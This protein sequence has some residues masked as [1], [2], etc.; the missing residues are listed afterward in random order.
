[1]ING[2]IRKKQQWLLAYFLLGIAVLALVVILILKHHHH[3][4]PVHKKPN[5]AGLTTNTDFVAANQ[6][7]AIVSQQEQMKR[8]QKKLATLNDQLKGIQSKQS[9]FSETLNKV[10][11]AQH[12]DHVSKPHQGSLSALSGKSHQG[13]SIQTNT[14]R[15]IGIGAQNLEALGRGAH[16][17][18]PINAGLVSMQSF[19]YQS[20]VITPLRSPKNYVPAGTFARAVIL[21][22]ADANASVNGQSDTSELIFRVLDNGII[23]GGAHSHLKNC[24]VLASVY[25]DIS[26]ER[27]IVRLQ[28][29]SCTFHKKRILD[30][31]VQ[32]WAFYSGKSGIKG[33]PV[34]RNGPVLMWAGLSGLLSGIG[35]SLSQ[36]QSV[37]STS[38]LGTTTT[39]PTSRIASSGLYSGAGTA[40]DKLANYYIKRADQYHP[41][42][43]IGAGNVATLVFEKGFSLNPD[44]KTPP[45]TKTPVQQDQT[46][47]PQNLLEQI[48]HSHMGQ[49]IGAQHG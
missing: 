45:Q 11:K 1:M 15:T 26:S 40:M 46:L 35:Q 28:H 4:A 14:S 16:R 49:S 27:G 31:P 13:D 33:V 20:E 36:S 48:R 18:M 2:A 34:M 17:P 3:K 39:V 7:S 43:E 42:I 24:T 38:A 47:I 5:L 8:L 25:G 9:H 37:Q 12:T 41:I 10:Q 6:T 29:L 19:T 32:G 22:G 21:G 30:I 23:P 44:Q